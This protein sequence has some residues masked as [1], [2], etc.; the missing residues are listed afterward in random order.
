M[1]QTCT[2]VYNHTSENVNVNVYVVDRFVS[3]NFGNL[4]F[5]NCVLSL[6]NHVRLMSF[7]QQKIQA[8][9]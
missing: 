7:F 3:N 2:I 4:S 8:F 1:L 9:F 5:S 6:G